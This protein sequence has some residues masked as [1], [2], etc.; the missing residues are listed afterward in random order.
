MCDFSLKI[1]MV[2]FLIPKKT[3]NSR[4]NEPPSTLI[5]SATS[6][7]AIT[8]FISSPIKTDTTICGF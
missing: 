7:A 8:A 1:Y 5:K 4:E 6:I 3:R 2:Y